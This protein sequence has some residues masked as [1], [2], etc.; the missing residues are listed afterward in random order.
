MSTYESERQL[1]IARNRTLIRELGLKYEEQ[2][3]MKESPA[4]K[5]KTVKVQQAPLRVSARLATVPKPSYTTPSPS[6]PPAKSQKRTQVKAEAKPPAGPVKTSGGRQ[7]DPET[8]RESWSAWEP[9]AE[10]PTRA[11]DGTFHF[12]THPTFKPNKA[13]AEI[14]R[15]GCFGGS[16]FRPLRSA[17]LGI[18]VSDDWRELPSEWIDGLNVERYLTSPYYDASVNKF[19]V[20]CGQSIEEWEANGWIAHE[21]DVRG[22]FQWYCRFSQGRRCEDDD[23][24]VGRWARCVGETG[25]WRRTLLKRYRQ[26]GVKTVWDDGADD[27]DEDGAGPSQGLS[28]VIHQTCHHWAW[29]VRQE[30]LD[31]L[32]AS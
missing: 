28:P 5:R 30:V 7:L 12:A 4:K 13:P 32:W 19:G 22:W 27:D 20:S 11:D 29:E 31:E 23:R 18:V 24:Q 16:Y 1:N 3:S 26:A 8:L 10:P 6:P 21:F 14:L 15:E 25:R 9:S 17:R 2:P